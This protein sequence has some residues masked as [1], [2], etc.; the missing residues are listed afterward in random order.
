MAQP[1]AAKRVPAE[2]VEDDPNEVE[3]AWAEEIERRLRAY[4]E[5]KTKAVSE[6]EFFAALDGTDEEG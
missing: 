5:G 2:K 4:R 3:S 1:D 6:E